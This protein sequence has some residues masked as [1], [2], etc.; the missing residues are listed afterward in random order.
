[1]SN[2]GRKSENLRPWKEGTAMERVRTFELGEKK[3]QQSC[4]RTIELERRGNNA[5]THHIRSFA[6]GG[7]TT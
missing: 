2:L 3:L 6:L 1:P 4:V 7:G 5:T